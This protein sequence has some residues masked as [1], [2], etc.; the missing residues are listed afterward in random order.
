MAYLRNLVQSRQRTCFQNGDVGNG[1]LEASLHV[2]ADDP[3]RLHSAVTQRDGDRVRHVV[4]LPVRQLALICAHHCDLR[5][6]LSWF[7]SLGLGAAKHTCLS[8]HVVSQLGKSQVP[9]TLGPINKKKICLQTK[10]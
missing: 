7:F 9:W 3:A 6:I 8:C 2:D 10:K 5:F 1:V 4:Q